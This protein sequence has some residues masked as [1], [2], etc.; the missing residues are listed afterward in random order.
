M[1]IAIT[2]AMKNLLDFTRPELQLELQKELS[3][4]RAPAFIAEQIFDWVYR[5]R[6]FRIESWSNLARQ[7]RDY[8]RANY[9][10]VLPRSIAVTTSKIDGTKKFLS[11]F[12]DDKTVETVIIPASGEVSR[13]TACLSSQVGCAVACSFCH[14]AS[15][16]LLR[17]LQTSE[18]VGQYLLADSMVDSSITNI[19]FMGQGEPLHNFRAVKNACEIFLDPKGLGLGQRKITLSTSGAVPQMEKLSEFPAINFAISLH[20]VRD[21][22]RSQ[23]MPINN[24]YSIDRLFNAI[25]KIPL[26]AHRYITYEYL[27]IKDLNDGPRDVIGLTKLLSLRGGNRPK[28]NIIPYNEIPGSPYKRPSEERINWFKNELLKR[29][30]VATVRVSKGRDIMAA[31]GQLKSESESENESIASSTSAR[32]GAFN[33]SAD[34]EKKEVNHVMGK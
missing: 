26:K 14:T 22:I 17:N 2:T 15:M 6:N 13:L 30:Q 24:L 19:V 18:I 29:R 1:A 12:L 32:K 3:E 31:C 20:A 11:R 33:L 8:L 4:A 28:V 23:L 7:T 27:L 34:L 16:G 21:E 5:K 25:K 9:E 10:L